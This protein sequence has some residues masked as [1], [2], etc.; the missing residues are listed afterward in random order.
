MT[1]DSASRPTEHSDHGDQTPQDAAAQEPK[2]RV[3]KRLMEQR[4]AKSESEPQAPPVPQAFVAEE[5]PE[6]VPKAGRREVEEVKKPKRPQATGRRLRRLLDEDI[7][8]ELDQVFGNFDESSLQETVTAKST[9]LDTPGSREPGETVHARV[10]SIHGDSVFVDIGAKSECA[11]PVMQFED[12][13]PKIGDLV[14][15]IVDRYDQRTDQYVLRRPGA[16]QEADWGSLEKGM[17]VDASVTGVNKGGLEVSVKGMRGF[18]PAGQVDLEH[19]PDLKVF[20]GQTLRCQV[21]EVDRT[22]KNL[23]LSR[24]AVLLK[25]REEQAQATLASLQ[26]GQVLEGVVRRVTDFGAFVDI[27]GVDGLI[28]VSQMSWFRVNHP[29]EIVS[30]GQ[31]VKVV[32]LSYDPESRKIGLGLRQLTDDPWMETERKYVTG[33][34]HTG[35]VTKLMDFGAFVELEPGVEGLVHISELANRRVT[36]VDSVVQVGQTVEVKVQ[37]VD[38]ERKRISLSMRAVLADE[39]AKAAAEAQAQAEAQEEQEAEQIKQE[40]AEKAKSRKSPLKG[41]L[42]GNSGPL[43]G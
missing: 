17:V 9:P 29:S 5:L 33:T 21:T 31:R 42:G 8:S 43:F 13:L 20:Q 36:R 4:Q 18:I 25:Q 35:T 30:V 16:A 15:L 14:D 41:G 22:S 39:E 34:V 23:V 1:S 19:I 10:L 12:G 28:H 7:E 37:D 11:V 27:G 2:S 40:L 6:D 3:A 38:R 26:E 32:V 24:K